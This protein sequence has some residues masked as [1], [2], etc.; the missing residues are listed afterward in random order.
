MKAKASSSQP[1]S[2]DDYKTIV[3]DGLSLARIVAEPV[4]AHTAAEPVPTPLTPALPIEE[5]LTVYG[6]FENLKKKL[7]AYEHRLEQ[8]DLARLIERAINTGKTGVFEAGTGI[9]KSLAALIPAAL[10]GKRVVVSTATISLQDQY[11]SKEIPLLRE[12]I[13]KNIEVALLKGRG[14]Y[15]GLRRYQDHLSEQGVD[16][17]FKDWVDGTDTGDIAELDFAPPFELWSE[18]NSDSDDC[19]RNK[20]PQFS[21]CFFFESRKRAEKADIIVVN[22]ALLLA[23]AASRGAILPDYQVLIVDEAHH[24]NSIATDAFSV[25]LTSRGIKRLATRALKRTHAPIQLVEDVEQAAHDLFYYLN[26]ELR[27]AKMRLHQPVEEA[28]DLNVALSELKRWLS[29]QTFDTI[30][31]VDMAKEK[32]KLKAKSII[33]NI[34]T[35]LQCLSL[36]M[37]PQL[38]WVTWVERQDNTGSRMSITSA[39]LDVSEYIADLL[40]ERRDLEST[41]FMSAT[42]ATSG[43]DPFRFFKQSCGIRGGVVQEKFLSPFDYANQSILYLPKLMPEPNSPQFLP[44]A[45]DQIER[46]IELSEGRAFVLFTSKYALSQTYDAVAPRLPYQ[47][48]KQ[49]D[50]SRPKLIEWFLSTPNAVLFGT[51]SFWEGVSI[52]GDQLSC[53]IIDRIPFQVPDDPVYEARCDQL[54][55]DSE[56][57][58]FADLALPHAITRL[59]QGVGRLIRTQSDYGAV[60]ILDPRLTTK[61]YGRKVV[62]CL[63][64]MK[65]TKDLKDVAAFFDSI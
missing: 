39:P 51:S 47:S 53:V 50:M 48:K 9:G 60:A 23:D 24:L 37:A 20:C 31:D 1:N 4:P 32:A 45:A 36:V 14:N 17:E 64:P 35:Y 33:S 40:L 52:D 49:G 28:Q 2:A 5:Q 62:S 55:G 7:S 13:G 12:I 61:P 10:S 21:N 46:L 58:W 43:D 56:R 57:S 63:P 44:A 42:L 38:D 15:L 26:S 30:L 11:V 27:Y 6:A 8:I 3:D 34:D 65:V 29:E 41:T 18:V 22:H 16:D 59:K 54:K 25:S 19:L